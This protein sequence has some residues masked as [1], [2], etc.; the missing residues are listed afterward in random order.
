MARN[1]HPRVLRGDKK[2]KSGAGTS[3]TPKEAPNTLRAKSTARVLDLLG[4]GPIVGLVNDAKGIYFDDTPIV[5]AADNA[6]FKGVVFHTRLGYPD[7]D[8]IPGFTSVEN[9]TNVSAEVKF[10]IPVTREI[11]GSSLNAVRVKVSMPA[12]TKANSSTGDLNGTTVSYTINI[13]SVTS[14]DSQAFTDTVTGKTVSLYTRAYRCELPGPSPWDITVTRNTA[15]ALDSSTQDKTYFGSYTTIIDGRFKYPDSAIVGLE[16]DAELFGGEIPARGYLVDGLIIQV[17]TNYDPVARTYATV[18]VGT[19]G[20]VWDG[21]F[22]NAWTNNP[23]WVLYDLLTNTRYGVGIDPANI[24]AG[25]FYTLSQYCDGS[26]PNGLGGNEPRFTFDY[27]I[28]T[29]EDAYQ[30]LQTVASSCRAMCFWAAGS[31][32]VVADMPADPVKLVTPANAINGDFSY[33]G[34]SLKARHSVVK[35]TWNDPEDLYQPAVEVVEDT[36]SVI[37]GLSFNETDVTIIGCTRRSQARRHGL[38]VLDTEKYGT[39]I[40]TYRASLD[41]ADVFPGDIIEVADPDYAGVRYGGRVYAATGSTITL[42]DN[43]TLGGGTFTAT[44]THADGTLETKTVTGTAVSGGRK[45]VTISGTWASTPPVGA[46]WILSGDVVPRQFRVLS[47]RELEDGTFE[48]SALFHDPNK[49]DRV[50]LGLKIGDPTYVRIDKTDTIPEP[51]NL[52]VDQTSYFA[53]NQTRTRLT[54]SWSPPDDVLARNYELRYLAPGELYTPVA[55]TGGLTYEVADAGLGDYTFQVRTVAVDGRV[56]AWATV[57]H[58]NTGKDVPPAAPTSLTVSQFVGSLKINW[59]LPADRDLKYTELWRA[60]VNNRASATLVATVDSSSF[61]DIGLTNGTTYYYWVRCV[62]TTGNIGPYNAGATSG[63]SGLVDWANVSTPGDTTPPSAPTSLSA[64][65]GL[66]LIWLEWTNPSASDLDLIY[67]YENS[68][69]SSGT[70]TII[71]TVPAV[72]SQHGNYIR[73]NLGNGTQKYYWLKAVDKSGNASAFSSGVNAT[74]LRL[75]LDDFS[76]TIRP[77]GRGSAL[78]TASTYDGDT[79]FLTTDQKLYRKNAA[80]TGW[81]V[82][83]PAS[84]VTGQ[85]TNSQI[86]DLA[87]AKL[88]GQIT[89]TQITDDAITTPKLLAG[90]VT[91][92]KIAANTIVAGNIAAD[93][94]TAA[95]IAAN[96]ITSNEL[97][98]NS[99]I[100]NKI[101]A[102][103]ITASHIASATITS[104]QIAAGTIVASNIAAGTITSTQIAAATIT[105]SNIASATITGTQI[106]ANTITASK[107][108]VSTL[109]AINADLGFVTAGIVSNSVGSTFFDMNNSRSQYAVGSYVYRLGSLGTGVVAWFGP[110]STSIGTETRTNGKWAFGDDG[111]VYYGTAELPTSSNG[112]KFTQDTQSCSYSSATGTVKTNAT[113]NTV[114]ITPSGGS[115]TYSYFWTVSCGDGS[116][117]AFATSPSTA[118]TAF[119]E[120]TMPVQD[121]EG[122]ATCLVTDTVSG[123]TVTATVQVAFANTP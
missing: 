118:T 2:S 114:T 117:S 90:A 94:I 34:S 87:A 115:G 92:T 119:R 89:T 113:T 85:L 31:V 26:V 13:V 95:E 21:T 56:S 73:S 96:A 77:V 79:F 68:S 86:A 14:G 110:S 11:S 58:G 88:T 20:G 51:I 45:V 40:L 10:G 80:G 57:T 123:F 103:V 44:V 105:A 99:V 101:A 98:A 17:P 42:D 91:T 69:N 81:Q 120:A 16:V 22:K 30:I 72:A 48:I 54:F 47:N 109:A 61:N 36:A 1:K 18:G 66:N 41:H 60:T 49:Y 23:A 93:T 67:V 121:F 28:S 70:A 37:E 76:S 62:D 7:Q 78:P 55:T 74:T 3:G 35:V 46:V 106:A 97:A 6:N 38:W 52:T 100:A 75:V 43:P 12:L 32:T 8:F 39:E 9:E 53:N 122:M 15:D 82:A 4:E 111:K 25:A 102:G 29:R 19:S 116:H 50:E 108:S 64:T 5:D 71:A 27:T 63:V 33:Q 59:T 107:I 65:P 24:D 104:T 83:V 84:D 112:L